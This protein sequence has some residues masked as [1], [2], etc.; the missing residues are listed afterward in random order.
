MSQLAQREGNAAHD[1]VV[2]A[3]LAPAGDDVVALFELFEEVGNVVGI[4]LQVAVHG[5]NELARGV[6]ETRRQ[7][8]GLAEVAAQLDDQHAAIDRGD[9]FQ[10]LVGAVAGA[11]VDKDQLKTVAHLLH[12][13]LQA[14]V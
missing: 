8:R 11:I 1:E 4:V 3:L 10:Q 9:L 5:E 6:V 13:L 14:R 12:H 2:N 7:R